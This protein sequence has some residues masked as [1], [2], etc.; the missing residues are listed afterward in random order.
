[1]T[2]VF[3]ER[4]KCLPTMPKAA[5]KMRSRKLFANELNGPIHPTLDCATKALVQVESVT[6]GGEVLLI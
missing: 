4:R 6:K 1:M 2:H 5:V 3:V